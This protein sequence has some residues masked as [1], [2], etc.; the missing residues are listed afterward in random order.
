MSAAHID[1]GRR[2]DA[3]TAAMRATLIVAPPRVTPEVGA[4]QFSEVPA[5]DSTRM[6][7]LFMRAFV[8]WHCRCPA[9]SL[10][11]TGALVAADL[12]K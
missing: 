11:I 6:F 8:Q 2:T 9:V 4:C 10:N 7:F 1:T 5:N 3:G 12:S